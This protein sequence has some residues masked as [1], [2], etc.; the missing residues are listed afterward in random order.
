MLDRLVW[1]GMF[2]GRFEDKTH[3]IEVFRQ[4]NTEV[5]RTTSR[6][7]LLVYE[8]KVGW[9]PL[10]EFLGVPV[11]KGKPFPHLNDAEEFRSRIRRAALFVRAIAYSVLGALFLFLAWVVMRLMS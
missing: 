3:A 4:H 5:Q 10:C 1:H 2:D 6:D 7:R 8:I 9:G 11:P